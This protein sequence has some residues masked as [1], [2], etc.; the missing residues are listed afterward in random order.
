MYIT[1]RPD[2]S[3]S[4]M[5]WLQL[6]QEVTTVVCSYTFSCCFQLGEWEEQGNAR[7]FQ[8][9]ALSPAEIEHKVLACSKGLR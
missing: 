2:K 4:E 6:E 8:K 1:S 9:Q 7:I 3:A 5:L